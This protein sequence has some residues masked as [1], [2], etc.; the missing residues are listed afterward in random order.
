MSQTLGVSL[1]ARFAVTSAEHAKSRKKVNPKNKT[2]TAATTAS[3]HDA[4][5]RLAN[6]LDVTRSSVIE[7][8]LEE[9]CAKHG[10]EVK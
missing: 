10:I 1:G 4:V 2:L 6:K 8:A 9:L 7:L 5:G 3:L